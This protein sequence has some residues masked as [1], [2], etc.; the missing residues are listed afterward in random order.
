MRLHQEKLPLQLREGTQGPQS[1]SQFGI[2]KFGGQ[3]EILVRN[4]LKRSLV[5]GEQHRH[6]EGRHVHV[7]ASHLIGKC[8]LNMAQ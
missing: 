4:F 8:Y 7:E 1:P 6:L 2:R 5:P 3:S